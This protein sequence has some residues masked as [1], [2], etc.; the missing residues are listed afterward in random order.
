MRAA[1]KPG[2]KLVLVEFRSEDPSVPIKTIHKMSKAQ[3]IAYSMQT[4][5]LFR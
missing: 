2:G 1:L 4:E 5:P 3:A